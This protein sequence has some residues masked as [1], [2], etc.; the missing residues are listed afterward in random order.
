MPS[1]LSKTLLDAGL[2]DASKAKA[3]ADRRLHERTRA[4]L[5][6]REGPARPES[7]TAGSRDVASRGTGPQGAGARGAVS[8]GS[9]SRRGGSPAERG[10]RPAGKHGSRRPRDEAPRPSW[11]GRAASSFVSDAQKARWEQPPGEWPAEEVIQEAKR[12]LKEGEHEGWRGSRSYH[13]CDGR[14][15]HTLRVTED[16]IR[17]LAQGQLAIV[18]GEEGYGLLQ[19][20]A[21]EWLLKLDAEKI[22]CWHHAEAKTMLEQ[23]R[24]RPPRPAEAEESVTESSPAAESSPAT[25]SG[26]DALRSLRRVRRTHRSLSVEEREGASVASGPAAT[27]MPTEAVPAAESSPA[28]A[29]STEAPPSEEPSSAEALPA[30]DR[31]RGDHPSGDHS[32]STAA[33]EDLPGELREG[34]RGNEVSQAG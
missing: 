27:E 11:Q 5:R 32:S 26:V 7:R 28:A 10:N 4:R 20:G 16:T 18:V 12:L 23:R 29:S 14:R 15:I 30:D 25:E 34:S 1:D 3:N 17:S 22:R 19:G 33:P 24:E 6:S 9:E 21:A 2:I 31:S 8:R 13:F